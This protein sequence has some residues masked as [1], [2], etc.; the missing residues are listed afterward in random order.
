MEATALGGK[1]DL[2]AYFSG[3][4]LVLYAIGAPLIIAV[5]FGL[6]AVV[7]DIS[8]GIEAAP[9]V[10]AG[11]GASLGLGNLFSA[12]LPYPMTKRVGNPLPVPAS[13]YAGY[14]LAGLIT[15]VGSGVLAAPAI[16]GVVLAANGPDTIRLGVLLPCAAVYGFVLATIGV[17]MAAKIAEHQMPELCQVALRTAT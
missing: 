2:R 9:V 1:R 10:L 16:A 15:L 12:A 5:C 3:Q 17:R 4:N 13:G 8:M 14:R 7:H 11:L 6:A